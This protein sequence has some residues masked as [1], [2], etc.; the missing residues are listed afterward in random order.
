MIDGTRLLVGKYHPGEDWS[1][2]YFR[3]VRDAYTQSANA[4]PHR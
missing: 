1:K 2:W 4:F 3:E